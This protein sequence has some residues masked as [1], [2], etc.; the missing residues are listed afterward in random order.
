MFSFGRSVLRIKPPSPNPASDQSNMTLVVNEPST[1][2]LE[3][4]NTLGQQ[5]TQLLYNQLFEPGTYILSLDMS[6]WASGN[7]F[8]RCNNDESIKVY[9]IL[10][11]TE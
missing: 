8:I 4:V 3:V 10:K 7:Y 11:N 5:I 6:A 9:R 1:L 2:S